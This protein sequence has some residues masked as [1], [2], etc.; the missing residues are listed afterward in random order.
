MYSYTHLDQ[1]VLV[2]PRTSL[3]NPV[4][5]H[6]KVQ[7]P[8][9]FTQYQLFCSVPAVVAS[10]KLYYFIS[11]FPGTC[12]STNSITAITEIE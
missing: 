6:L 5:S 11:L 10:M 7:L 9:C 12:P 3:Q 4:S 8:I 1:T 2:G